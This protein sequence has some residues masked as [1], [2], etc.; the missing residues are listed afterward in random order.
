MIKSKTMKIGDWVVAFICIILIFIC[1]LPIL[2]VLARSLSSADALV[3]SKVLFLP[4]DLNF[5]AY[6]TVL[7]DSRFI[8]SIA[9][10]VILTAIC[11]CVSLFMTVLCAY[12][13][14][15]DNLKGRKIFS[16]IMI[17][18]MYFNAGM[19][20]NYLLLKDLSLLNHPAVLVIPGALS[21]FNMIIMRSFFYGIPVSLRESAQIDGASFIQI[22]FKIYLPLSKPVIATLCLF[23][24]VGRWNGFS[25]ALMFM[26]KREYYP[27]QLL[28][29]NILNNVNQVEIAMMEGFNQP[30]LSETLK[31]A[32]VMIA[33]IPILMVYPRLQKYFIK[34]ATLGAVKE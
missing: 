31:S 29:Y 12:P 19:I 30:G 2:T 9:W 11:T 28:L 33:T 26:N 15:Y 14:I 17:I 10:T 22:L 25:D 1:V 8:W 23:Y 4:V 20:P 5:A 16:T 13:L 34:G 18:T 21:V 32:A 24:A 6:K 3:K 27:I 7:S